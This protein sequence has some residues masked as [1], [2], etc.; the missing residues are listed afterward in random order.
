MI[1]SKPVRLLS[2]AIVASVVWAGIH[3]VV[4]SVGFGSDL[5]HGRHGAGPPPAGKRTAAVVEYVL[6]GDTIAVTTRD[7]TN[8][9]VRLLGIN[10]P[11]IP[12]RRK[13]GE[14]YGHRSTQNLKQLLRPGTAAVLVSDPTQSD[15]DTYGRW[16]R[17]VETGGRDI[18]HAQLAAGA[19][20]SR[21]DSEA[22]S[23]KASYQQ[24][25]T[26]ARGRGA[27]MWSACR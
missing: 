2:L 10:A 22:V 20:T 27:G 14:C 16:L 5:L 6:D 26:Y 18:G 19:A 9:R 3:G 12:H 25:A 17:Y 4:G 15:V 23:R 24:T 8:A 11:E 1:A 21:H 13:P 7:G